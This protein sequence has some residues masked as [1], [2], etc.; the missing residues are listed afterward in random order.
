MGCFSAGNSGF[1]PFFTPAGVYLTVS[2]CVGN[3]F[4]SNV[5]EPGGPGFG[6]GLFGRE[7]V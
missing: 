5:P 7:L 4:C 2:P 6:W 1:S 3:D